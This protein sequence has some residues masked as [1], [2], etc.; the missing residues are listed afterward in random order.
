M[1][2]LSSFWLVAST[3][4]LL[5]QQV[6]SKICAMRFGLGVK[7]GLSVGGVPKMYSILGLS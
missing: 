2:Y 7:G 1:V 3:G 6:N 5:L 4:H